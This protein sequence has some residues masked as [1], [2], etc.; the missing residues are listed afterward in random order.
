MRKDRALLADKGTVTYAIEPSGSEYAVKRS[1]LGAFDDVEEDLARF[2]DV[3]TAFVV[4][5]ALCEQEHKR[6]GYPPEDNRIQ[7][8][9]RPEESTVCHRVW[10][11]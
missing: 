9:E 4:A 11:G 6:L 5:Y 10:P 2:D 8:P 1:W 3:D 7:Y